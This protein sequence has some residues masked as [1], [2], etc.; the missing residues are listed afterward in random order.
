MKILIPKTIGIA[1]EETQAKVSSSIIPIIYIS[2][3]S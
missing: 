1:K 2:T 3:M